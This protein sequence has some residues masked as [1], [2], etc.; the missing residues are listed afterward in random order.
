MGKARNLKEPEKTL[1]EQ[2]L[3]K[4]QGKI[5][6]TIRKVQGRAEITLELKT[7]EI[8][9]QARVSLLIE[10]KNT[11]RNPAEQLKIQLLPSRNFTT[12]AN[13]IRLETL[14][15]ESSI[16]LEFQIQPAEKE[17]FQ[18][19]FRVQYSDREE[20]NKIKTFTDHVYLYQV[21]RAYREIPNPYI[22]GRPIKPEEKQMFFGREDILQYIQERLRGVYRDSIIVLKGQ[23]RTGKTSILYQLMDRLGEDYI[24]VLID[25]QGIIDPGS[26]VFFYSIAKS[27]YDALRSREPGGAHRGASLQP[28]APGSPPIERPRLEDFAESPALTFRDQ[29]LEKVLE[30][31]KPKRIVFMID[32]F[33]EIA[34]RIQD[35][36][37][38]KQVPEFLRNLMQHSSRISFILAGTERLG[39]MAGEYWNILF[40]IALFKDIS[41]LDPSETTQLIKKPVQGY[42]D[43]DDLAVEKILNL[44]AG[45]P[46][47]T[48]LLCH[49]LVE[50]QNRV[51]KS[52]VTVSDIQ[53]VVDE[54]VETGVSH[55]KFIFDQADADERKVLIVLSKI[56]ETEGTPGVSEAALLKALKAHGVEMDA[57]RLRA[58][59]TQLVAKGILE[60][61]QVPGNPG[62]R[63]RV[64][65][66]RV[67]V[68]RTQEL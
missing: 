5:L 38:D 32:E 8:L 39:E 62:Y 47:F 12:Q 54:M 9:R 13:T 53:A 57:R 46:Y 43:Y 65:L 40:N 17:D 33:E 4:I 50:H 52:F 2:V 25:L 66:V 37:L 28:Q 68:V 51:K 64:D 19:G 27:L 24:P 31:I 58:A 48:Q 23:R 21:T 20:K 36:K 29:F 34:S 10:V 59:L 15:A 41:F 26:D 45:H 63:F 3:L 55:F 67:W 35:G 14:A 6:E 18:V 61:R 49:L 1:F 30:R 11:G 44:T 22:T 42:L 56:L 7:R 16:I 60:K